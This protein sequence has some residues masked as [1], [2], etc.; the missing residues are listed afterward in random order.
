[1][2]DGSQAYIRGID[3]SQGI[4]A[5]ALHPNKRF[6]AICE[7]A[8]QA[9]CIIYELTSQGPKR[10]RILTSSDCRSNEFIHCSF[11]S[12]EKAS[13]YLVTTVSKSKP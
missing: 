6:L 9:I 3:G 2:E 12:N 5:M 4:T 13:Q 1:M 8:K 7:K 10:R 11:N